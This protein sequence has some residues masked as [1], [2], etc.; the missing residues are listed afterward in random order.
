MN[1][2]KKTL[3][4][5]LFSLLL[6]S[7]LVMNVIAMLPFQNAAAVLP[8]LQANNIQSELHRPAALSTYDI[9]EVVGI[10]DFYE[11]LSEVDNRLIWAYCEGLGSSPQTWF[12]FNANYTLLDSCTADSDRGDEKFCPSPPQGH[13]YPSQG[14]LSFVMID[15]GC[16]IQK[17]TKNST[18]DIYVSDSMT[19]GAC[20]T[21]QLV[22]DQAGFYWHTSTADDKVRMFNLFGM[23]T[24][25]ASPSLDDGGAMDCDTPVGAAADFDAFK[26]YIVCDNGD[27]QTYLLSADFD[28]T[29]PNYTWGG[30]IERL[31]ISPDNA[32]AN[33]Q[34]TVQQ[35]AIKNEVLVFGCD[36][37][38]DII[39]VSHDNDGTG[40]TL[41]NNLVTGSVRNHGLCEPYSSNFLICGVATDGSYD[42]WVY[43]GTSVPYQVA[44]V[45]CSGCLVGGETSFNGY[46][47]GSTWI[48]PAADNDNGAGWLVVEGVAE[49]FPYTPLAPEDFD[50][51]CVVEEDEDCDNIPDT[52]DPDCDGDGIANAADTDDESDCV[53]NNED[54]PTAPNLG[55]DDYTPGSIPA[56]LIDAL[57]AGGGFT[58]ETAGLLWTIIIHAG[59]FGGM[60]IA[61]AK[62]APGAGINA[63]VVFIFFILAGALSLSMGFMPLLFFLAEMAVLGLGLALTTGKLIGGGGGGV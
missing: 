38:G 20:G 35:I 13:I 48:M 14:G 40:L 62:I 5:P 18:H 36:A 57:T 1:H 45:N 2:V 44:T 15:A 29:A 34:V 49:A 7:A 52:S 31:A 61:Q 59:L 27:G 50:E 47:F 8:V 28:Y 43:N 23:F 37:T 60:L 10:T 22:Y 11:S 19:V 16:E 46:N 56:N 30:K 53:V 9:C 17:V 33:D 12:V 3:P 26:I 39:R 54:N 24:H 6:A 63:S 41:E 21:S 55:G 4:S 32:C 25:F 42:F 58:A 51:T